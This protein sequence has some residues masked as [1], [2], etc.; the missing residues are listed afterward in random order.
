M[1]TPNKLPRYVTP[2]GAAQYPK[3][4]QPDT[5]FNPDGDYKVIQIKHKGDNRG[6]SWYSIL[7]LADT[8]QYSTLQQAKATDQDYRSSYN[9]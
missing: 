8:S 2:K 6:Q 1:S 4:N 7:I 9:Q 3:L 5:K